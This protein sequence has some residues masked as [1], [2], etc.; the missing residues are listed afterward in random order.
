MA[1]GAVELVPGVSAGTV[2][3]L[4][5]IY[6]EFI[7]ALKAFST[8]FPVLKKDGVKGAWKHVNGNFLLV[9]CAGM[10]IGVVSLL[11]LIKYLLP[12][13]IN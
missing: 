4:S 3:L 6:E 7:D 5:G 13:V 10:A 11:K 8:V 9:L 2:A 1:M 12:F